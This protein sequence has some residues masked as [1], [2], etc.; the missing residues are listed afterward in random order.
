MKNAPAPQFDDPLRS[1]DEASRRALALLW[2]ADS[3]PLAAAPPDALPALRAKLALDAPAAP[4][5]RSWRIVAFAGWA[6]AACLAVL[7]WQGPQHAPEVVVQPVKDKAA[8]PGPV[9]P[10]KQPAPES[11]APE[12]AT[13]QPLNDPAALRR[14][15]AKL[16]ESLKTAPGTPLGTHRPVIRELLPPGSAA[17]AAGGDHVFDLL[18]N[19]LESELSRRSPSGDARELIIESGWANWT[20]A[21]PPDTTFRHRS[22]PASRWE[23]LG[24]LKGAGGQFLDPATGWLWS[25]DPSGTDYTGRVA[26]ADL[27]RTAFVPAEED[28]AIATTTSVPA[29]WLLTGAKGETII[30]LNN[31]PALPEGGSIRFNTFTTDG[32]RISY[33]LPDST[34]TSDGWNF[35]GYI[36][37]NSGADLDRGFTLEVLSPTGASDVILGTVDLTQP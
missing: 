35:S 28:R 10:D 11:A 26:P 27:D 23:E 30:A 22:F 32:S 16:K 14:Q 29:G 8:R 25:P 31:L 1:E 24:L 33:G 12:S 7:L 5:R 2:L 17:S 37:S 6:A 15:L 21:L 18:A 19:A 9:V 13:V 3:S 4:R 36:P 20:A 34:A